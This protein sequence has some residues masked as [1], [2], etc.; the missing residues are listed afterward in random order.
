LLEEKNKIII[1][2]EDDTK[3]VGLI[4]KILKF[5]LEKNLYY[6]QLKK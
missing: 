3:R 4:K 6:S 2:E 5:Y 1:L